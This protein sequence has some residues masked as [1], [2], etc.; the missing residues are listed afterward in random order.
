MARLFVFAIGGTGSRVLKSLTMLLAAG[1]KPQAEREYEIV[2]IIIDPHK[3]NKDLQ[4]TTDLM[5]WYYKIVSEVGTG[6]GFFATPVTTLDKLSSKETKLQNNFTFNLQ[7]VSDTRFREYLNY[8]SLS[9]VDKAFTDLMFSGRTINKNGQQTDLLDIEMDIGFVGNPNVG[10]VVL[11]QFKDSDEFKMF[12]TQFSEHDRVFIV[13]SIFGGTGAAGFPIILKNLRNAEFLTNEGGGHTLDNVGS[14]TN[15]RIG[16]LTVLPYF[17]LDNDPKSPIQKSDFIAKTKA[18]LYYY[19]EN[20]TGNRSVNAMYYIGDDFVGKP[21][22]NDPGD[23]GQQNKAHIVELASALA[24]I[25]FLEI[26]DS[27][28]NCVEGKANSP[29]YREFGIKEDVSLVNMLHLGNKTQREIDLKLSQLFF[30]KKYVDEQLKSSLNHQAW[31]T[32]SR[33]DSPAISNSFLTTP[34]Y[35]DFFTRFMNSY[36]QWLTELSDNSRGFAPFNLKSPLK[37]SINEIKPKS[38]FMTKEIDYAGYDDELSGFSFGNF[39]SV[40]QKFIKIFFSATEKMLTKK[41]DHFK[42]ISK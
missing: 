5:D 21:Y 9:E 4:R 15:A 8:N 1:V 16:A 30:F 37:A 10:S 20:I 3:S 24:I 14:L 26:P 29:V 11:N 6:N 38:G 40:S 28:L 17:N 27:Q 33:P 42:A 13:S 12:S 36:S 18:A 41:F 31:S 19:K 22:P 23:D 25:D 7:E 39:S 34:F 32:D 35:R 2:P